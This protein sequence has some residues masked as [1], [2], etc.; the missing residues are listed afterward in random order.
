M[1]TTTLA[2]FNRRSRRLLGGRESIVLTSAGRPV[3]VVAP[4][5]SGTMSDHLT[6]M[7]NILRESG[8]SKK[9]ALLALGRARKTA[10]RR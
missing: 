10:Y 2:D 6:A 4:V 1:R 8:I 3:A 7:G 5:P 9:Q